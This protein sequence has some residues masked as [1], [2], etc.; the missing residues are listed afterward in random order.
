MGRSNWEIDS[1]LA[2]ALAEVQSADAFVTEG[3]Q[4]NGLSGDQSL[5]VQIEDGQ[6][7]ESG[8]FSANAFFTRS[9]DPS[10]LGVENIRFS[11]WLRLTKEDLFPYEADADLGLASGLRILFP[12][13]VAGG[14]TGSGD[15]YGTFMTTLAFPLG[16]VQNITPSV[17]FIK[18]VDQ[19]FWIQNP[20][21]SPASLVPILGIGVDEEV[22]RYDSYVC[23]ASGNRIRYGSRLSRL[24]GS[25]TPTLSSL[26]AINFE[27]DPEE[28]LVEVLEGVPVYSALEHLSPSRMFSFFV[29]FA[30]LYSDTQTSF[31]ASIQ[32]DDIIVE[33]G[34]EDD[35]FEDGPSPIDTL[36]GALLATG[37]PKPGTR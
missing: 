30:G 2:G 8:V 1:I 9:A 32:L 16:V 25:G 22:F 3:S 31:S 7:T 28:L 14:P 6:I 13:A 10:S 12:G 37:D 15:E 29:L 20:F 18:I 34:E 35:L 19:Y 33:E 5:T 4:F 21:A 17:N 36:V 26:G 11:M 23:R 24:D 27:Y